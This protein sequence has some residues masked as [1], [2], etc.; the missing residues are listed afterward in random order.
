MYQTA[1]GIFRL[2]HSNLFRTRILQ[3]IT[4][5]LANLL[6]NFWYEPTVELVPFGLFGSEY[7]IYHSSFF[8]FINIKYMCCLL[9]GLLQL[10]ASFR[11]FMLGVMSS[12][13]N[14][15]QFSSYLS[16]LNA[17]Q[18]WYHTAW[19]WSASLWAWPYRWRC[20]AY[21]T[22]RVLFAGPVQQ[23]FNRFFVVLV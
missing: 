11:C 22:P 18:S 16:A 15:T 10:T 3:V 21:Q 12:Q 13:N 4:I 23:Y 8:V 2:A 9:C 19:C 6:I 7:V 14:N 5:S 1:R 17:L 20:W